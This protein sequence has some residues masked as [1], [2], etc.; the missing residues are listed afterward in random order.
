MSAITVD[1]DGDDGA[2]RSRPRAAAVARPRRCAGPRPKPSPPASRRACA[3]ARSCSTRCSPT[4]R[5]TTGCATTTRGS[6]AAT[7]PTRRATSRCRRSSTR[8]R[9]R[10]DIPQRWYALKAQL[11]G[12]DTPRRLRPHGV[13]RRHRGGDRLE[14]G[15]A[16]SCSTRTR[17][18]R[19][20]SPTPRSGSSTAWID[21]PV[22]PGKRPGAFCAYTVPSHHPYLLL[23]WTVA[24]ARRADA[25]ARARPRPARVPRA[26]RRASSTRPRRSRWP[27]PRRCSARPSPSAGCST[28]ST[29]RRSASRCSRRTSRTRSPPCSGRSR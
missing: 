27:R 7:W 9:R 6:R 28:R 25:R 4:R 21:A 17:R 18:S 11:L 15:D 3:P 13:G 19:P 22:R 14:R 29:T 16:S 8:C 24:A 10:Y 20:S 26:C 12:L 23:N 1:L 5:P 2:A